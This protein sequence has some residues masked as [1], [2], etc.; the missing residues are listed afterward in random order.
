[1][2]ITFSAD[3]F[4]HLKQKIEQVSIHKRI[5]SRNMK[6]LI[7]EHPDIRKGIKAGSQ[8][9]RERV[10]DYSPRRRYLM[11]VSRNKIFQDLFKTDPDFNIFFNWI[12]QI[13]IDLG[14]SDIQFA[15]MLGLKDARM[16]RAYYKRERFPSEYTYS[17]LLYWERRSKIKIIPGKSLICIKNKGITRNIQLPKMESKK[18]YAIN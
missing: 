7:A 8:A 6:E 2:P 1:M 15:R 16:L 10:K 4:F 13:Q 18:A 14:V 9:N 3:C 12:K 17:R 5:V 11:K